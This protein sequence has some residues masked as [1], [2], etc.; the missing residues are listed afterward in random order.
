MFGQNLIKT[1]LDENKN[2]SSKIILTH[3]KTAQFLTKKSFG[4][5]Q[6]PSE[7]VSFYDLS[8]LQS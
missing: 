4:Q 6:E 8:Q 7:L 5:I 1:K 2:T 3:C